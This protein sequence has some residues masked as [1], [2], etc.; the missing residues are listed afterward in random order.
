[1]LKLIRRNGIHIRIENIPRFLMLIQNA[2]ISSVLTIV[3]RIKFSHKVDVTL[4]KKPPVF[5]IGHWRTGTTFLHQLINLD[6]QFTTPTVLQ[7]SIP[8]HFL[9]SS[10]YYVPIMK[11]F[12]PKK[13]HMDNVFI[14]PS[15]PQEDEFA[16]LRMG[17]QSPMEH[18]FF[19]KGNKYF[20]SDFNK[21]LPEGQEFIVWKSKLLT[22]YK[23]I[24]YITGKQIVSKNPYHTLRIHLLLKLFPGAKFIHVT[25]NALDVVPSTIAMWNTIAASDNLGKAWKSP[26]IKEVTAVFK[27]FDEFVEEFRQKAGKG[28]ITSVRFEDLEKDPLKE[29]QRIYRDLGLTYTGHF[30]IKAQHFTESLKGYVKNKFRLTEKER[31]TIQEVM[32]ESIIDCLLE[33]RP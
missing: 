13:R 8:D 12:L 31:N 10:R 4:L 18:L 33:T 22:F 32:Q 2:I 9:F 7:A 21:Y 24:T 1:L 27:H 17:V 26:G 20:L 25:R 5:I 23:K 14:S 11:K 15:E 29:L 16:L 28:C 3:E 30:N 6:D 19:Y